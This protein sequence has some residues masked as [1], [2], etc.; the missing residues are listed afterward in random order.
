MGTEFKLML[1]ISPMIANSIFSP[2][3]QTF[4]QTLLTDAEQ[5]NMW[6]VVFSTNTKS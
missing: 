2:A 5:E 3:S 1:K 6:G 4:L